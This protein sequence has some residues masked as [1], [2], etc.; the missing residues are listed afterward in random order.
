MSVAALLVAAGSVLAQGQPPNEQPKKDAPAKKEPAKPAP[1]S[2]EDTLDKS[3]RNSADIKAAEAKVR[4]AEAEL[5]KVRHQVLT[6]ATALHSDLNLAKRM[7][8]VAEQTLA[9]QER[10]TKQGVAQVDGMLAAQAIVEKHRGEVEKLEAELKSIRGEFALSRHRGVVSSVA[11]SPDGQLLAESLE[12]SVRLWDAVT[13]KLIVDRD[14][15]AWEWSRLAATAALQPT[16]AERIRKFL[17]TDVSFPQLLKATNGDL[18]LGGLVSTLQTLTKSD[19]PIHKVQ[20]VADQRWNVDLEAKGT[21]PV[22]AI[23]QSF[24]DQAP[25]IRIVVRE[26]GLFI[27]PK[28]RV[29]EGA[30]GVV[31]FWK[32]KVQTPKSE[33]KGPEKK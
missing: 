32:G 8:A 31:D 23:L 6:K 4:E 5:N 1:G 16:M 25:E 12:G 3:L 14:A 17:D 24:E 10:L 15:P 18:S 20:N 28:D 26:Y 33:P 29:P 22:G 11:F 13:G 9:T 7:L 21:L 2:L 19:V 27:T 30:V